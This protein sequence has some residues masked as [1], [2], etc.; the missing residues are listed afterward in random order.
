MRVLTFIILIIPTILQAQE[1]VLLSNES[2]YVKS[3]LV[4]YLVTDGSAVSIQDTSYLFTRQL[5][6]IGTVEADGVF[7]FGLMESHAKEYIFLRGSGEIVILDLTDISESLIRLGN[8]LK[9]NQ[10]TDQGKIKSIIDDVFAIVDKNKK[11]LP[12]YGNDN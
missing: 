8:F 12:S 1:K 5:Q 4:H 3:Y 9:Q 10:I 11:R 6:K 7:S 2:D